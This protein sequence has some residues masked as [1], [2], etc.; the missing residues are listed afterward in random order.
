MR[1]WLVAEEGA[2]PRTELPIAFMRLSPDIPEKQVAVKAASGRD[3]SKNRVTFTTDALDGAGLVTNAVALDGADI[4]SPQSTVAPPRNDAVIEAARVG[5][6][7]EAADPVSVLNTALA[8][9]ALA[10]LKLK[11]AT[12]R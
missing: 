12:A 5:A 8:F 4:A 6:A 2:T 11:S 7:P 9:A 3:I 1:P 10:K